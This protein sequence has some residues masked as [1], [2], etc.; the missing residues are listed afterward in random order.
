MA[1]GAS[2]QENLLNTNAGK[3][4]SNAQ[5]AYGG[6]MGG[7]QG[8][9]QNP[10]YSGSDKAAITSSALDP[11]TSTFGSATQNLYDQAA[12]TRN[13]ASTNATADQLARS[14]ASAL[15]NASGG[16]AENFAS[17]AMNERD[18]ALS[19]MAGLYA[20]SVSGAGNLYGHATTAME[21]RPSVLQDVS[22]VAGI[23]AG[24]GTAG[25]GA[26]STIAHAARGGNVRK[27]QPVIVGEEGP[28]LF[29]PD[30]GGRVI[31]NPYSRRAS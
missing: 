26:Y 17:T 16:L 9:V 22:Q 14:K 29:V 8:I 12:R 13:N 3:L 4:M 23:A 30:T 10:G 11:I 19:G 6:A 15:S 20:P 28:E 27:K 1:R 5:A 7:Y 31:P 21:A 24:L 2:Q 18:R 25:V